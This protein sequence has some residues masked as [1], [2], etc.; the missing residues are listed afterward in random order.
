MWIKKEESGHDEDEHRNQFA[1]CKYVAGD[2]GLAH[3]NQ[4][5]RCQRNHHERNDDCSVEW[6][7]RTRPEKREI[8][9]QQIAVSGEGA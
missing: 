3:A 4:I 8:A 7:G 1:D 2:G 5:N 6:Y 9:D